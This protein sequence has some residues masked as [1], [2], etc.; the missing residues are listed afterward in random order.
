MDSVAVPEPGPRGNGSVSITA[1]GVVVIAAYIGAQMIADIGSLKIA[2]VAGFSVDGG[3]FIYPFTFTLRDM[4]H[5]LLGY[6]AARN[7]VVAA[8]HGISATSSFL[9]PPPS[10]LSRNDGVEVRGRGR[11]PWATTRQ[12]PFCPADRD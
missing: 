10:R 6:R 2:M 8:K 3:T 11:H 7:V 9:T 4:V 12:H 5:K 1:A